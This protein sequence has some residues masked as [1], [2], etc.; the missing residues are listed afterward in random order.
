MGEEY[1]FVLKKAQ[2]KYTKITVFLYGPTNSGKTMSGLYLA[3]G[4]SGDWSKIAV[5]DTEGNRASHYAFLG[6]YMVLE[7]EA[8]YTPEKYL[9]AIDY[10]EENEGVETIIIDS[11]SHIWIGM[12]G[13][14]DI[15]KSG[16][17]QNDFVNWKAVDQVTYRLVDK[18]LKPKKHLICTARSKMKYELQKNDKGKLEPT[19]IGLQPQLRSGLEYEFIVGFSIDSQHQATCTKDTTFM[20]TDFKNTMLDSYHGE[21]LRK[22]ADN[23]PKEEIVAGTSTQSELVEKICAEF[24]A[25]DDLI[26]LDLRGKAYK[27]QIKGMSTIDMS[28]VMACYATRKQEILQKAARK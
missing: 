15:V 17:S 19:R 7:L 12:G 21:W 25:V 16:A 28:T 22:W 23:I 4:L 14:L 8:P 18:I 24:K 13:M 11:F 27:T 20:F 26:T 2:R 6:D 10:L 9:A 1:N 5:I 3:K